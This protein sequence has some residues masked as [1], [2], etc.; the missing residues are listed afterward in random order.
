MRSTRKGR[1]E[2][3]KVALSIRASKLWS[4]GVTEE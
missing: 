2:R 1:S 3:V 4:G